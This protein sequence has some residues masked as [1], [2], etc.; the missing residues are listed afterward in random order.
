VRTGITQEQVDRAAD[1][2]LGAG[3]NP[4]VEKI[5]AWLGTGSPNTVTRMLD[6]WRNRLGDRLR[7]LSAL[8]DVPDLVGQ[9]MV[10]LWRLAVE[11]AN[12][13]AVAN[14]ASE[15]TALE[16]ARAELVQEAESWK[17]RLMAADAENAQAKAAFELTERARQE[18]D[19]HL[20]NSEALCT[21]LG[22][23]RDRLQDIGDR[24]AL[25]IKELRVLLED[26]DGELRRDREQK[27]SHLRNVE[28]R[29]HQEVDR[30][31]LEAKQWQHRYETSE[32]AH[33]GALAT[34]QKERDLLRDQLRK[35]DSEAARAAGVVSA[36]EKVLA[37]S[38]AGTPQRS[39]AK[40]GVIG[41]AAAK[42]SRKSPVRSKKKKTP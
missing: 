22:L 35:A 24:Q 34:L 2:I 4:T 11:H 26:R 23:Q 17:T 19:T 29:A 5:R 18:L 21:D 27:E 14:L 13:E 15:G 41:D 3:E 33:Q 36:L 39:K 6:A 20:R 25:E 32:R 16:S 38:R 12:R 31:R 37:N 9:A 28:N 30:A 7:E 42:R 40:T 8:P 1:A 10:D